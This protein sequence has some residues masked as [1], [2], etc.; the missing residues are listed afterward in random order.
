MFAG[1]PQVRKKLGKTTFPKKSGKSEDNL[2]LVRKIQNLANGQG[3]ME[4]DSKNFRLHL[5]L[6]QPSTMYEFLFG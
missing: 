6:W 3:K 5:H 1:F 2:I 4:Q